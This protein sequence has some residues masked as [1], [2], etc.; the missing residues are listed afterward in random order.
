MI[1]TANEEISTFENQ[2][3]GWQIPQR[4]QREC[5][6]IQDL[7]MKNEEPK[8][9]ENIDLSYWHRWTRTHTNLIASDI[10]ERD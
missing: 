2:G 6:P 4:I 9:I 10:I 3:E 8:I 5:F 1:E 7:F